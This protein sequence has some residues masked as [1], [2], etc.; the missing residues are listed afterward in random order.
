MSCRRGKLPAFDDPA[1]R[2]PVDKGNLRMREAAN[3]EHRGHGE[4]AGIST[5][6]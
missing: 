2:E 4:G 3:P 1:Q 5:R 6:P